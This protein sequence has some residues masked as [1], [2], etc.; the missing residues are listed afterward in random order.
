MSRREF[1]LIDGTSRKFWSIELD[2]KAHTVQF[3]R[4]GTAGQT[5]RKEFDTSAEARASYDKL[6][7]EKVKKGYV[8]TSG[9]TTVP[10]PTA[11]AVARKPVRAKPA[12]KVEE[13]AATPPPREPQPETQG[14]TTIEP[15]SAVRAIHL[16]PDDWLWA[17]WRPRVPR[18]RPSR[19]R[20]TSSPAWTDSPR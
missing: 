10:S 6:I 8:E 16:D 1:E 18:P 11:S 4:I 13:T 3:G 19:R 9:P 20:S 14:A 2:D 17:T 12:P 5:R 15:L 7:A